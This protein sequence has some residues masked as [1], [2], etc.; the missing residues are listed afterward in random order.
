MNQF[1]KEW[2]TLYFISKVVGN[3]LLKAKF[4]YDILQ[5]NKSYIEIYTAR[6]EKN[7]VMCKCNF[8]LQNQ[9]DILYNSK[10][11]L[12]FIQ[13]SLDYIQK[14][15]ITKCALMR[16]FFNN[17][18]WNEPTVFSKIMYYI[19][20]WSIQWLH[21]DN[22]IYFKRNRITLFTFWVLVIIKGRP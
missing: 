18:A 6:Q 7:Y 19:Q 15:Q 9:N 17:L 2:I 1:F 21:N 4:H 8:P 10:N 14:F 20:K 3:F 16:I 5:N 22:T 13:K 12:F 11:N